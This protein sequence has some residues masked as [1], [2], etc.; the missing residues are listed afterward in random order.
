MFPGFVMRV[1]R[2]LHGKVHGGA[3]ARLAEVVEKLTAGL[4]VMRRKRQLFQSVALSFLMWLTI[5]ASVLLG[6]RAFNLPLRFT[7]M[8]LLIVPLGLGIVT[9]TPGAPPI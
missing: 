8:F 1:M 6:V 5:D 9:P 4:G 2:G 3:L 7:D